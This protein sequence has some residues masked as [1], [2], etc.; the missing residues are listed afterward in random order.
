MCQLRFESVAQGLSCS[1]EELNINKTALNGCVQM[2]VLQ[3][4][5]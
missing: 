1:E 2:A 4:V 5:L 3:L